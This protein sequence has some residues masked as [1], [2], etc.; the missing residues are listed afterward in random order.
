[1]YEKVNAGKDRLIEWIID[2]KNCDTLQERKEVRESLR[3]KSYE[4][5]FKVL[6]KGA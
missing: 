2:R 5:L 1:M 4:E 3:G 6:N